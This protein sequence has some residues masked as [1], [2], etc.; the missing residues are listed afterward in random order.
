[1][2]DAPT[3]SG[4]NTERVQSQ[5]SVDG[6]QGGGT[7][8]LVTYKA[9][10]GD[11][12]YT[13]TDGAKPTQGLDIGEKWTDPTYGLGLGDFTA[14]CWFYLPTGSYDTGAKPY[15]IF[16][17]HFDIGSGWGGTAKED[18]GFVVVPNFN[19]T[20]QINWQYTDQ[21][22]SP[23]GPAKSDVSGTGFVDNWHW[24][25]VCRKGVATGNVG[26][27]FDGTRVDTDTMLSPTSFDDT[28]NTDMVLGNGG[29]NGWGTAAIH[30][31]P[32]YING[33]FTVKGTAIYDPADTTIA[34]GDWPGQSAPSCL[35]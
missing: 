3:T 29:V 4:V 23:N 1:V 15:G 10:Y 32:G 14:S 22:G 18:W 17:N 2:Y 19:G 12:S 9:E 31:W 35:T 21:G 16:G 13:G 20:F 33:C 5:N 28:N 26:L 25:V 24:L 34:A 7:Y 27:W 30:A 11:A 6:P 8:S